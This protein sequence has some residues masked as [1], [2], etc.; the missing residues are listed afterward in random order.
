MIELTYDTTH[1]ALRVKG[2]MYAD[3]WLSFRGANDAAVAV[4]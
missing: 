3:G 2:N 1:N 4:P